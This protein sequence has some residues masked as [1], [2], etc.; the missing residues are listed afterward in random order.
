MM[1]ILVR[2][3]KDNAIKLFL[4]RLACACLICCVANHV[5]VLPGHDGLGHCLFV[6]SVT[7]YSSRTLANY[8][9]NSRFIV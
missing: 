7:I 5:Q 1:R 9:V 3:L 6:Y 4:E 8:P 2:L